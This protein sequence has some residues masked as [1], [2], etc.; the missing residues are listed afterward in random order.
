MF[1]LKSICIFKVNTLLYRITS[2]YLWDKYDGNEVFI[3][4]SKHVPNL[5]S[6]VVFIGIYSLFGCMMCGQFSVYGIVFMCVWKGVRER[7]CVCEGERERERE[8][9]RVREWE[10]ERARERESEGGGGEGQ[11][12]CIHVHVC[13]KKERE[14][15]KICVWERVCVANLYWS[16]ASLTKATV[17]QARYNYAC[18]A[19][20]KRYLMYSSHI[21]FAK[22]WAQ[23]YTCTLL[24]RCT[25]TYV[26]CSPGI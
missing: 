21:D 7:V 26:S 17:S 2:I 10:S 24:C 23:I 9:E 25:Y 6:L 3:S 1:F 11:I 19:R 12:K 13:I 15:E 16:Q 20:C 8:S 22:N 4:W 14:R 5:A 18:S